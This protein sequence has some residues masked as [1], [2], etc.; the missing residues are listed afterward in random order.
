MV[1]LDNFLAQ[2]VVGQV[3]GDGLDAGNPLGIAYSILHP[4]D[5]TYLPYK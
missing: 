1:L 3:L 5:L 4:L 2:G